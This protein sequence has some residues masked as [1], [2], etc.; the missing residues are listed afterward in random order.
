M[1][2][3]LGGLRKAFMENHLTTTVSRVSDK[4]KNE[5]K[6][7]N[8]IEW[9]TLFRRNWHIYADMILQI[10][11]K[12]FQMVMLFLMGISDTFFAI[13]SRGL[14][15]T[16]IVGL[17]A[18]IKMLLFPYSEVV[19][20]ASTI[21][22]ANV[23]VEKKIR[24]ELIKKLSPYLLHL[25]EKEYLVITRSDDGYKIVCTLN[26]STLEV[27]PCSESSRGRRATFLIYEECR[28]LKKGLIDSVFEKMA[29]PRQAK[30]LENPI[31]A[32][33]KRWLEECQS[34]YITSARYKFEWFWRTF[35]DCFTGHFKDKKTSYNIFAGDIFMSIDNGLKTWGDLRK[36]KKMSS[37]M[38]Y[39][40]E[41][42]NEM[43]GEAEDAFF[44]IQNFKENQI[45]AQAFIPPTKIDLYTMKDIGNPIKADNE[46][47]LVI[48]DYAFANTTSREANDNTIIMLM[49][50]HWKKNRFERHIDYIEGHP[51]SDSL[52]AADRA[53]ELMWDYQADY[54]IPD[55]RSGGEVLYNKSTTP[56]E[57]DK[58]IGNRKSC[59]LTISTEKELHVV[60][61]NKLQDLTLR[62][63]DKNAWACMIPVVGTTELNAIMW[64][65]LKKQLESN[66]IKF[67]LSMQDRQT[68]L[69]DDGRYFKLTS[70]ELAQDLLPYG[71]TEMMID[72]AV[73][74]TA[75]FKEGRVKLKEPRSGTKD[76]AVCLSYG[77][78]IASKIE[79]QVVQSMQN[80]SDVNWDELELVW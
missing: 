78:Y 68:V 56:W 47:R 53:R 25:Y 16:F 18:L 50:L 73:K 39:R 22:Q 4:N 20:T 24:D 59:G 35:K 51:A 70:E 27:L 45:L 34:I 30:Y 63:V 37:E 66:N 28:L 54:F 76:R 1:R 62:T 23:I 71:Q 55:L 48:T 79:N 21:A 13:C 11:L 19:I 7:Y 6:E 40:M 75:E 17:A 46:I 9:T 72:E 69:E 65:E 80:N 29:H 38:D 33:D 52:G 32:N 15:K 67:L 14:S 2:S 58:C 49:S 8:I 57:A 74:L 60:P 77:N 3:Q 41:D 64:M 42:L 36:A 10:K 61:E 31:Y 12:P 26:G 5:D 44:K 43:I